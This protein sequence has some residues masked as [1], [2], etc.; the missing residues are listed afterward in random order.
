MKDL[1][2]KIVDPGALGIPDVN[3]VQK[4]AGAMVMAY[5]VIAILILLNLTI[6]LMNATIQKFQDRKILYWKCEITSVLIEFFDCPN[7]LYLPVT[8]SAIIVFWK[9]VGQP[10]INFCRF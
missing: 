3:P 2:W 7:K 8:F 1:G 5:H 6:T 4:F 10:F 9:V